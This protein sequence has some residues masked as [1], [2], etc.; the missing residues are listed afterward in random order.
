MD[1]HK[2]E[3]VQMVDPI[4][5]AAI[6]A[7]AFALFAGKALE[8][9]GSD[10]GEALTSG[11]KR[12]V[13]WVRRRGNEDPE[14]AAAVRQVEDAP[15]DKKRVMQLARAIEARSLSDQEF[16]RELIAH[17]DAAPEAMTLVLNG[18]NYVGRVSGKAKVTQISGN[19]INLGEPRS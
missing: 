16:Q 17:I 18:G 19:Q 10:A 3:T 8:G 1:L 5:A 13:D 9:A 6:A 12:L 11:A 7:G 14:T 4:T 15:G 2:G